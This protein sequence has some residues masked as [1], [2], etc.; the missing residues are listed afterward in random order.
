MLNFAYIQLTRTH[1]EVER[2]FILTGSSDK[3][4][5]IIYRQSSLPFVHFSS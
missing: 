4:K 5:M 2:G 1:Y 3:K